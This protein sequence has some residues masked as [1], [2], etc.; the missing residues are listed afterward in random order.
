MMPDLSGA[1]KRWT[2]TAKFFTLL[3]LL[4]LTKDKGLGLSQN[5]RVSGQRLCLLIHQI[6][7]FSVPMPLFLFVK[8]CAIL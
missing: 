1:G 3:L 8:N 4:Y 6:S 7:V 2:G 5:R